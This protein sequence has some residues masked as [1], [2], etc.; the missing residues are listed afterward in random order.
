MRAA[1]GGLS[2]SAF[3]GCHLHRTVGSGNRRK[4]SGKEMQILATG[5]QRSVLQNGKNEGNQGNGQE[6]RSVCCCCCVC[7]FGG[8]TCEDQQAPSILN[9]G[10]VIC[11]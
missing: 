5:N 9:P 8:G 1:P 2:S 6:S 11:Y 3:S 4:P 10:H 7:V